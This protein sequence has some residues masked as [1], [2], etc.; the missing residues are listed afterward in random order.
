[1]RVENAKRVSAWRYILHERTVQFG[2]ERL[3][4]KLQ[5]IA[6]LRDAD[7]AALRTL[8]IN[9]KSVP[10][11]TE[12]VT[13]GDRPTECCLLLEGLVCRSRTTLEGRRQILS[14]HTPGDIPD[15]QSLHLHVMDHTVATLPS[16]TL[17]FILHSKLRAVTR[18]Y[19]NIAAAMWRDTLI[20]AAIFREWMLGLGRRS[21]EQRMAH[22]LCE[23]ARRLE[24]VGLQQDGIY[25]LAVT[26]IDLADALGLSNVHVNRVLQKLRTEGLLRLDRS[27]VSIL[28]W[29]GLSRLGEFEALYL[30]QNPSV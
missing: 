1:L 3:I 6:E 9:V 29:E 24:A 16:C 25:E 26:Q 21:A 8:P 22:L 17:G 11:N 20:D 2:H 12:I 4:T 5:S 18:D 14:F 13:E 7:L 15:L 30:H 23:M 27:T 28:D 19:P 10:A